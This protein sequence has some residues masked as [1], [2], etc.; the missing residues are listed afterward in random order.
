MDAGIPF[1]EEIN[2]FQPLFMD[3]LFGESAKTQAENVK[4]EAKAFK[5]KAESP[6]QSPR[7][8]QDLKNNGLSGSETF[9]PEA[10]EKESPERIVIFYKNRI[11]REYLPG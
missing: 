3:D 7:K 4:E 2:V 5:N 8:D 1:S 11:F 9:S 10:F 6:K